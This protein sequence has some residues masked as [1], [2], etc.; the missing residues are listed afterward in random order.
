[1][2]VLTKT[3]YKSLKNK[4]MTPMT[5]EEITFVV[6]AIFIGLATS[7]TALY[8]IRRMSHKE[9]QKEAFSHKN[10]PNCG[11]SFLNRIPISVLFVSPVELENGKIEQQI[12]KILICS[13]CL[14]S[15]SKLKRE[16][17]INNL[18]L[19]SYEER[20]IDLIMA[21]VEKCKEELCL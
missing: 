14:Y 8:L 1:M 7:L 12:Q 15:E 3:K 10:C 21:A 18:R 16:I 4:A 6:S 9:W 17:M 20:E 2:L 19:F 13:E 5:P 11:S